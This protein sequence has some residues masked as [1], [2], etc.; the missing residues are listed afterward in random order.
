MSSHL[1]HRRVSASLLATNLAVCLAAAAQA[2]SVVT[3]NEVMYHPT[4]ETAALEW[5]E[6]HNPM[7]VHVDLSGWSLAGGVQFQFPEGTVIAGGGW[8]V[9]ASA[10]ATL[11]SMNGLTN[12]VGPF[13][14]RL[15]NDGDTLRLFNRTHRLMD[16]VKYG[17]DGD[18]PV[19]ADGGGPS[20]SKRNEDLASENAASWT[21]SPRLGGTPG[22]RNFP[23]NT[24]EVIATRPIPF[25]ATW[26]YQITGTDPGPAWSEPS[27]DDAAWPADQ[28][29]FQAG[30]P[31]PP[32]DE[33]EL[34]PTLFSTGVGADANVLPPGT[35]DPHY[36]LTLSAQGSPPPPAIAATVIEN[37]PAWVANDAASSWIG[38]VNPGTENVADGAYHYRTTFSLDGYDPASAQLT[39][40]VGAD[41]HLDNVLLNGV[42]RGIAF[43]GFWAM[44][45]PFALNDGFVAGTNTLDFLTINDGPGANP[46]GF[47][48]VLHGTARRQFRVHT[49]L[50]AAPATAYFRTRFLHDA[51]PAQTVASLRTI[52]A[53][54]AVFFLNG[55]EVLRLNLPEGSITPATPALTNVPVASVLGPF[56]LPSAALRRGTNTLAVELH[57][58]ANSPPDLLFGAELSLQTTNILIPPPLPI[59]FNEI[60][61]ATT[62]APFW[63]ELINL[64]PASQE[65]AGLH[66]QRAGSG[67]NQTVQLPARTLAP[68]AQLELGE[69]ELGFQPAPGDRLF[70]DTED[71]TQLLDAVVIHQTGRTR[72]P[73][74][75]GPWL[76]STT[77]TPGAPN[78]VS[79][80]RDVVINEIMYHTPRLQGTNAG[81]SPESWV[82]L[83]NRG[84][85]P[86]D[87]AGWRLAGD[88]DFTF[89][90][91]TSLPPD[92]YLVVAGDVAF[93]QALEPGLMVHGPFGG[94]LR[95]GGG[96]IQLKDANGNPADTVRYA[97]S[98]PWPD[99]ADGGGSSL[100][101][102]NAWCDRSRPEAW[103]ASRIAPTGWS[104]YAYTAT[105]SSTL[106]PTLWN[107]FTLGLLDAG[108]CLLDD[109]SVVESPAGTPVE[110]IANGNFEGG[111]AGW[112]P[113]GTHDQ[114]RVEVDPDNPANHV[115]HVVSTGW[116]YH[117]S[118]HVETTFAGNR[119]I[120]NGRQYRVSFRARW[121]N[122]NPRLNTRLYFNRV[123]RTTELAMTARHGTPGR[124]NSTWSAHL[125]PTFSGLR[126]DP[127]VPAATSPVTVSVNVADPDGIAGVTLR[128]SANGKP[129]QSV[130]MSPTSTPDPA[131]YTPF[132]GRIPAQPA[133]SIV[134]FYVEAG[135][136]LSLTNTAPPAGPASR[137]C[138]PVDDGSAR[139][140][141]VHRFRLVMPPADAAAL[142]APTNVMS[143][144]WR[145]ATV[146][147]DEREAFYDAALHLQSSERGRNEN[148]RVGFAVRLPADHLLRGV[149]QRLTFDRS[150]GYSGRGG[151]HD[152]MLLWHAVNHAGGLL[153]LECDLGQLFAPRADE[154]STILIRQSAFDGDY[155]DRQFD[156]GSNGQLFKLELIYYPLTTVNGDP[157][158]PKLPQPDDVVNVDLQDWGASAENYRWIFLQ[159]NHADADDYSRMMSVSKA[160]AQSGATLEA[161]TGQLLD[162]DEWLRTLAFKAFAG[163]ADTFTYGYNHNWQFYFRPDDGRALGLLWDMD[164]AFALS[165][166]YGFPGGASA[167]TA[168]FVNLPN[169]LRRYYNHLLDLLTTTVNA[170]H[171]RPWATHYAGLVGQNWNGAVDYLQQRADFIRARLPLTTT[172]AITSNGGQGYAT[173]SERVTL[174]GTAPMTVKEIAVN[175]LRLPL[176]WTSLTGWRMTVP[177]PAYANALG[178]QGFDSQGQLLP[179]A[180]ASLVITNLGAAPRLP[181]IINEWMADNVGP[182]GFPEPGDGRFADW[183]ELYNPNP[184]AVN[185]GGYLLT[186]TPL[187]PAQWAFPTNTTIAPNDFLL[188]WAD[189]R[190]ELTGPDGLH[191]NFQLAKGG[192]M[193]ALSAPDGTLQHQ[194]NFGAQNANLSQGLIPDGNTNAIVLMPDWTPGAPNRSDPLPAPQLESFTLTPDGQAAFAFTTR[195]GRVYR[196]DRTDDLVPANWLPVSTNRADGAAMVVHAP[197][198]DGAQRFYRV[199]LLP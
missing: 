22:R 62:N 18:W 79:I 199:L 112:R 2:E 195:T 119:P 27:F 91:D 191:V 73:D 47:R 102:R 101:L 6:L 131:A 182:G 25:D 193:I 64:G 111:L 41:N 86:V 151:R 194:V 172:F 16:E 116:T 34:I 89:G 181:V 177:L 188:L 103:A 154:N 67:T 110:L 71:G 144:A 76:H 32:G 84:T 127:I 107:E 88:I 198:G 157:R 183:F 31:S 143:Y 4:G 163:D 99:Q 121:L 146:I 7:A 171:L 150:G 42:S 106:G 149:Q 5:V 165:P 139:M 142:H 176:T 124:Q 26:R 167:G 50:D 29:L 105:A 180:T 40:S 117:L 120:T 161:Q 174:T 78:A 173:T 189:G 187:Q 130:A 12:V 152:E 114:S 147:Y 123:A 98:S 19:G 109:V 184:V 66:L 135:D 141:A 57:R 169:N 83:Y 133:G 45:S 74:G 108:E 68:G 49:H 138:Y 104:N 81:P 136:L 140:S 160:F 52:A 17:V 1:P 90:P 197:A 46:A 70:L 175:G 186:D 87:L 93:L 158:A 24:I 82:E 137:A 129:W 95:H 30:Q 132:T 23:T 9:V 36:Q 53:D 20:L 15:G 55:R 156:Q 190:P 153:G 166:D 179:N 170:A 164:F 10:P 11:A 155:F 48:A 185:L 65:L 44:S 85:Q 196:V 159:G 96:E 51:S 39:L 80:I 69:D 21:V 145:P 115:F 148:Y 192:E 94:R 72:L 97:D 38:P 113:L 92:G 63:L 54:G 37:H 28:A 100:E 168:R 13:T 178:F 58:A 43:V 122:G 59:V 8:L 162:T 128:W 77:P 125:G 33:P 56:T 3:F 134:Q 75:T 14:G 35:A 126:H 60:A 61:P 118:D